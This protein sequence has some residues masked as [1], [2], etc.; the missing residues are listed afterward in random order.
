M[1]KGTDDNLLLELLEGLDIDCVKHSVILAS[2][3][4]CFLC[5]RRF[6]SDTVSL[7]RS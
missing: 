3:E 4:A 2:M 7:R 5:I 1:S 6:P